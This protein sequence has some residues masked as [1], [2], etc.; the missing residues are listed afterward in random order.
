MTQ[1][2]SGK[3]RK[4]DK[5]REQQHPHG[6][7]GPGPAQRSSV[8]RV[9]CQYRWDADVHIRQVYLRSKARALLH[10]LFSDLLFLSDDNDQSRVLTAFKFNNQPI[11]GELRL[12]GW[13]WGF[14][15]KLRSQTGKVAPPGF[16]AALQGPP[17]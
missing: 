14:T 15:R 1:V 9:V 4:S 13:G 7:R 16:K 3:I 5:K 10:L 17:G 12:K 6:S 2:L 8:L 11:E